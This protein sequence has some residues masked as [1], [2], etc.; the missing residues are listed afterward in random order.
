MRGGGGGAG[1]LAVGQ[2]LRVVRVA[3]DA[4]ATG[5][6]GG[7]TVVVLATAYS[8]VGAVESV[9]GSQTNARLEG[10]LTLSPDSDLGIDDGG[11]EDGCRSCDREGL[12]NHG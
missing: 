10:E 4:S 11:T 12:T 3:E 9:P 7:G 2:A 1:D 6:A 8:F 5:S